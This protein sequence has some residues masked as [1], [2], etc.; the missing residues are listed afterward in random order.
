MRTHGFYILVFSVL[1]LTSCRR[2][3]LSLE[4]VP[5]N[6]PK[7]AQIFVAGSFNNWNPGDPNYL[8]E[9]DES[10]KTYSVNLPIGFGK[11][12]YKFTRGDWT[13]V[14][15]DACGGELANR[16]LNYSEVE[17][18]TDSIVGWKDLEPENCERITLIIQRLPSNTPKGSV[19]YLGGDVNGWQCNNE[20]YQFKYTK[21]SLL[22]L[23]VPRNSD[24]L[25][26]K[27]TRGTWESTELN[28]SGTDQM[29]RELQFGK[30]DTVY[31]SINAWMDMP[32]EEMRTQTIIVQSQPKGSQGTLYLASNLNN[33]NPLDGRY[34]FNK[35][36]DGRSFITVTYSGGE[37]FVYKVTRGGWQTVET[38]RSFM[39]IENRELPEDKDTVYIRIEAWADL[40]PGIAKRTPPA[41]V[42]QAP[43]ASP[44]PAPPVQV[45]PP[46][47]QADVFPE[48]P[49]SRR[50]VFI[51]LNKTPEYR[52]NETIYLA[53]DF[54]GWN[55][56]D[57]NYAFRNLPNGKKFILLRLSDNQRHEFK[58]TRG[59]WDKEESNSRKER[60]E[61]RVINQGS[62]D[63]TLYINVQ[64]WYDE[65]V[66]RPVV[67]V[68][69]AI[70]ENTSA[71]ESLYLSGDFNDWL[72]NDEKY[73][74]K[75][76]ADGK[77]VLTIA[78]FSRR[79]GFYKITRGSWE[80]EA[81]TRSGRIP[82]NQQFKQYSNDTI[83]VR[84][85]R[86]KDR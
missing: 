26:Y 71:T 40:A 13:T 29:Q 6:T 24:K 28:E 46:T 45:I 38:D 65:S 78:D 67:M 57:P 68:L 15:T 69:T 51:I 43:P 2:V 62:E 22:L 66:E 5:T 79:Y 58:I 72:V 23:T 11:V 44:P 9:W 47:K 41:V 42:R 63:D 85:E 59:S 17:F 55:E 73:K 75:R 36:P 19:I 52:K 61:N 12:D 82:G 14:E 39:D 50:K 18:E 34:R 83:R 49:D 1:A 86:W 21:D 80:T 27:I 10:S 84:I 35:L 32:T 74:F 3:T 81:T 77:Y 56:R 16:T 54:N 64:S 60:I 48:D 4:K 30:Q 20:R 25:V 8:M 37:N 31:L 33:W 53:G 7:G 70:P 76:L